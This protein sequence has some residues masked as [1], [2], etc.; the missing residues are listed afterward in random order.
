MTGRAAGFLSAS[1]CA[2]GCCI[3]VP[4]AAAGRR[5]PRVGWRGCSRPPTRAAP[6]FGLGG[7][8]SVT[9]APE[10]AWL[11]WHSTPSRRGAHSTRRACYVN[12]AV[13]LGVE[14][15]A[16]RLAAAVDPAR[17][18]RPPPPPSPAGRA[19]TG[20]PPRAADQALVR[21]VTR[22]LHGVPCSGT[23]RCAVTEVVRVGL[24]PVRG[25]RPGPGVPGLGQRDTWSMSRAEARS[26][27]RR[28]SRSTSGRRTGC[29][30]SR[31]PG[32]PRPR[33]SAPRCGCRT[34]RRRRR[35]R[36]EE[37]PVVAGADLARHGTWS[38]AWVSVPDHCVS[39]WAGPATKRQ[40]RQMRGPGRPSRGAHGVDWRL[41]ATGT[42]CTPDRLLR[43]AHPEPVIGTAT[44]P[45]G[46]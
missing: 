7:R 39:A 42:S 15:V 13:E 25:P 10:A 19:G 37:I 20:Q 16:E 29:T 46:R 17:A 3:P 8:L 2:I 28:R 24:A 36:V 11:W 27:R 14:L 4:P 35:P 12:R 1:L 6:T 34:R 44:A 22:S 38:I 40:D 23:A 18:D 21:R 33:R 9:I 31:R 26:A 32:R 43:R 30:T 45:R 41:R 5:R